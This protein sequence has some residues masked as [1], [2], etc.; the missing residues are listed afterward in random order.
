MNTWTVKE[1]WAGRGGAA[2]ATANDYGA[3]AWDRAASAR[4][5]ITL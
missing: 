5:L 2:T 3:G 1:E 4:Q